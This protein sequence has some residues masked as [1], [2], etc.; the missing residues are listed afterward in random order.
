MWATCWLLRRSEL[1]GRPLFDDR[2]PMYDE[3]LDFCYRMH[4]AV[5]GSCTARRSA[6]STTEG[7]VAVRRPRSS[8][9]MRKARERF[10]RVHH[11]R[12]GRAGLSA[13]DRAHLAGEAQVGA[14][15]DGGG[16]SRAEATASPPAPSPRPTVSFVPSSMRMNAPGRAVVAVGVDD[17][18][19]GE[20]ER[21]A[22]DLV[23]P[24]LGRLGVAVQGVDVERVAQVVDDR[25]RLARRCG[26]SSSGCARSSGSSDIQQT[27]ASS[28]RTTFGALCGRAI[29]SPRETSTSSARRIVTDSGAKASSSGPSW[30]SIASIVVVLP[31]GQDDDLVARAEHAAGDLA[32]VAAVVV[33][34]VAHRPDHLLDGEPV[35]DQ[36]AVRGDVDVLEVVEQRRTR[37][38]RAC[39]P[40][41]RRRC[42]RAAR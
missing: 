9:L 6:S 14:W 13:W 32:G 33:V 34:L 28:S 20:L 40:S 30:V 16:V 2:F 1:A 36:V 41:G 37:R 11:G 3:D 4:E 15:A 10:Y 8:Q 39:S 7:R 19:L 24:E 42:R 5:A 18:R 27:V 17:E 29:T 26:G 22:A 35:V 23:Q 38:T 31:G 21:D 25:P 12:C